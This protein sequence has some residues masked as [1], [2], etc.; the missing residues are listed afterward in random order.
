MKLRI[1]YPTALDEWNT[2]KY[3][4][5]DKLIIEYPDGGEQSLEFLLN[6]VRNKIEEEKN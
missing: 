1:K 2:F 3:I 4:D 6:W 5:T